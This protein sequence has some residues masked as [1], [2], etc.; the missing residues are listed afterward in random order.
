MQQQRWLTAHAGWSRVGWWSCV[1]GWG[2]W[3]WLAGAARAVEQAELEYA[4]GIVEYGQ[5]NYLPALDHFRAAV[6]LAPDDANAAFYLGLT[7]SRL[8][9]FAEAVRALERALQLD[10]A[11][12]H[13]HYPLGVA[14]VQE[15]RYAESLKQLQLAERFDPKSAAVYFYRGLAHYQMK[16][17]KE[18]LPSLDRALQLEPRPTL[19]VQYYR[20]LTLYELERDSQAREALETIRQAEP[21]SVLGRNAQRYLEAIKQRASEQRL[22]QVQGSLS[23][24]YDDNVIL[25]PNALEISR[26]SDVRVIFAGEARLIPLRT[27][28]WYLGAKY[29]IFQSGHFKLHDF[30]IQNHAIEAF[31]RLQLDPVTVRLSAGYHYTL[32]DS[33]RF[34]QAFVVQPSATIRA[35]DTLFTVVSLQYRIDDYFGA[36][37]SGQVAAVRNRD[38]DSI[39]AGFE[40]YWLFDNKRSFVSL[41][42]SYDG[43][44]SDGSDWEY[45]G[46]D[47][48][49]G[50]QLFVGAATTVNLGGGYSRRNYLHINSFDATELG[51]LDSSDQ[52]KRRDDL[53]TASIAVSH[54][55]NAFFTV[56][57]GYTHTSN[58][59]NLSFFDYRRNIWT[60]AL[61]G[62]Y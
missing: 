17:Y 61:S 60:V 7:Q 36:L 53:F 18:A 21:D 13:A 4:K 24:Q 29:N 3:L 28:S 58:L 2:L 38:G 62:R 41:G 42:Y 30:D 20:G 11:L 15:E 45:N 44:R 19:P 47:V 16:Q 12:Q 14:Y 10:P 37:P 22:W 25:E 6:A 56:S 34:S 52:R 26:E 49:V 43:L 32:L 55:L 46:H 1:L 54:D 33:S 51:I 9:E 5:S 35:T 31:G 8:G 27:P 23:L 57:A 39:R 48:T 40:Q 50:L 59:S